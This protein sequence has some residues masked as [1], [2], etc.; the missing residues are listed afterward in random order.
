MQPLSDDPLV[1]ED[2]DEKTGENDPSTRATSVVSEIDTIHLQSSHPKKQPKTHNCLSPNTT[3]PI[4]KPTTSPFDRPITLNITLF[5]NRIEQT[6]RENNREAIIIIL[7]FLR[8]YRYLISFRAILKLKK[9]NI[10]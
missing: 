7:F 4:I 10:K 1:V 3:E 2:D 9:F 8:Y 6:I 5:H